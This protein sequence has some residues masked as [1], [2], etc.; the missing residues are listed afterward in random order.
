[1]WSPASAT[2]V[3]EAIK[4]SDLEETLTF[5][6]KE[7]LP[8]AK[9]NIS[10]A[11]DI[12]AMT[13]EGGQLLYGVGED[14]DGRPTV[15]KPVELAGVRERIDQIAQTSIAEPPY[16]EITAYPLDG[17]SARGYVLV[18]VPQSARAPHQVTVGKEFRYYGR[19]DTGSRILTE[20]EVARLYARRERWEIDARD[21]LEQTV[22]LAPFAPVDEAGYLHAFARPVAPNR[23]IWERATRDD[24]EPLFLRMRSAAASA[25][26]SEGYDPAIRGIG[27]NWRRRGADAWTLDSGAD[28]P[29]YAVRVD[30]NIDGRGSLF[31][32]RAADMLAPNYVP[33]TGPELVLIEVVVA[34]NLASFLALM[35]EY[36][37]S[38]NHVGLV[39]LGVAVTGIQDALSLY[40]RGRGGFDRGKYDAP[41]YTRTSRVPAT[42]LR[43]EPEV[44]AME[45][46]R[47]LMDASAGD[48]HDPYG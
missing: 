38:G 33:N 44:I 40:R 26:P 3:E 41:A 35:G 19:G 36:Y 8:A 17:D 21:L 20:G 2:E 48:G 34:G 25:P 47:D 31:C 13:P 7:A 1:M 4:R 24:R 9:K 32:G 23:A 12:C 30:V 29:S 39:D 42:R 16:I 37:D 10:L 5:D 46:I 45:L 27:P 6:A 43:K 22:A 15:L 11:I 18:T 14:H 28:S